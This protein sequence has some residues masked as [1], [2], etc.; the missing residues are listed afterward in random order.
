MTVDRFVRCQRIDAQLTFKPVNYCRVL[1]L[2]V[3]LR[4]PDTAWLAF[5]YVWCGFL[6]G[7]LSQDFVIVVL[8]FGDDMI[9]IQLF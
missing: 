7:Y 9:G 3:D 8:L 4:R 5:Q 1:I 6:C 2:N